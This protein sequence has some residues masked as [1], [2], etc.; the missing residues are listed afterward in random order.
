[1]PRFDLI[2]PIGF[3]EGHDTDA[4]LPIIVVSSRRFATASRPPEKTPGS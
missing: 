3:I 2:R 1:L 4:S